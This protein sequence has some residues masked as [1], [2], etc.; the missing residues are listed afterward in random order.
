MPKIKYIIKLKII[1]YY[2]NINCNLIIEA[3]DE[4]VDLGIVFY[5]TLSLQSSITK[6]EN[7]MIRKLESVCTNTGGFAEIYCFKYNDIILYMSMIKN[8]ILRYSKNIAHYC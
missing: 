5:R 7:V 8:R 1:R 2:Y 6:L 4:I 3:Y